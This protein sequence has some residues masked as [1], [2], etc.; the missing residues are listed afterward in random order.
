MEVNDFTDWC[1]FCGNKFTGANPCWNDGGVRHMA[2]GLL[3]HRDGECMSCARRRD[4]SDRNGK[5]V[6]GL[7]GISLSWDFSWH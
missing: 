7:T 2:S 6:A 4:A 3:L 5:M 1:S